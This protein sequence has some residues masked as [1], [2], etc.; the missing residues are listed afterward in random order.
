M[1]RNAE[2]DSGPLILSEDVRKS[3][4]ERLPVSRFTLGL[5]KPR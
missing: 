2:A 4:R 5:N 1:G 3:V